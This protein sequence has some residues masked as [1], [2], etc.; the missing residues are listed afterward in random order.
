M[1]HDDA[2]TP[3]PV[4]QGDPFALLPGKQ[5]P[6][7]DPPFPQLR[8]VFVLP[9]SQAFEEATDVPLAQ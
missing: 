6:Q 8:L 2:V 1:S 7:G 4:S 5:R 3:L 9:G